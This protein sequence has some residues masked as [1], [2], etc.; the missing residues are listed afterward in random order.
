M[1]AK[2]DED[3][4]YPIPTD[5]EQQRRIKAEFLRRWL[6]HLAD[7]GADEL[8]EQAIEQ[9]IQ[10]GTKEAL[11]QAIEQAYKRSTGWNTLRS[12]Y[13]HLFERRLSRW[14]T[15]SEQETLC[16]RLLKLGAFRIGDVV[17]DLD[18]TALAAW[19]ADPAAC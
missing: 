2:E 17:L 18:A 7:E 10:Q 14:L 3:R 16:Q 4:P 5:P 11:V 19:L 15:P 6:R 13:Q 8:V 12:L 9:A 1:E